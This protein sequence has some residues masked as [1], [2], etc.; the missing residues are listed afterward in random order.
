M[1]T[2]IA[3]ANVSFAVILIIVGNNAQNKII[4]IRKVFHFTL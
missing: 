1:S 2:N 3:G 4:C